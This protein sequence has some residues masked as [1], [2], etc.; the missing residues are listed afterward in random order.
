MTSES[1]NQIAEWLGFLSSAALAWQAFRLISHQK[2]VKRLR[3]LSARRSGTKM[4]ELAGKGAA[5]LEQFTQSWD[6]RDQWLVFIGVGGLA[7]SFLFKLFA[8]GSR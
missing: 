8:L 2:L 4:G 7:L 3:D 1:L 6:A 5:K